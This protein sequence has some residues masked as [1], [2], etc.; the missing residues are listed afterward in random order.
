M[1]GGLTNQPC[2]I[3]NI[4]WLEGVCLLRTPKDSFDVSSDYGTYL[5]LRALVRVNIILMT[6]SKTLQQQCPSSWDQNIL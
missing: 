1:V 2:G 4:T 6:S 5:I 3:W